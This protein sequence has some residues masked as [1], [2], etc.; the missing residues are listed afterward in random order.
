MHFDA[1]CAITG[2]DIVDRYAIMYHLNRQGSIVLNLRIYT[3]KDNPVIK[4]VTLFFPG[5][6]MYERE[7]M[8][9]LGIKVE[10]LPE[11]GRYPLPDNW[12]KDEHPLRK[13]WKAGASKKENQNA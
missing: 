6:E 3:G 4:T 1:I 13:D 9:L 10:G 2:M 7:M 11:G 12:P 5:A 8:D